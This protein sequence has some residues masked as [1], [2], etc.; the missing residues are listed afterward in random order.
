MIASIEPLASGFCL[1]DPQDA[2][3]IYITKL[4]RRFGEFLHSA[5]LSLQRQGE[6]N[7][8][9]AVQML[10]CT[11]MVFHGLTAYFSHFWRSVQ[12]APICS[13]MATA[14]TGLWYFTCVNVAQHLTQLLCKLRPIPLR[15]RCSSSIFRA[16]GLAARSLCPKGSVNSINIFSCFDFLILHVLDFIIPVDFYGTPLSELEVHLRTPCWTMLLNGQCGIIRQ[17]N[18]RS[19]FHVHEYFWL[20]SRTYSAAVSGF[21]YISLVENLNF[22]SR[23]SQSLLESLTSVGVY[24]CYECRGRIIYH[25]CRYTTVF[26][27]ELFQHCTQPYSLVLMTIAWKERCGHWIY[28]R[29]VSHASWQRCN[30]FNHLLRAICDIGWVIHMSFFEVARLFFR[31]DVSAR[32]HSAAPWVPP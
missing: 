19:W 25:T 18:D 7:T 20:I 29:L 13:S 4:R 30:S 14:R 28:H 1:T 27:F 9:D 23:A 16:E 22:C 21:Q 10:V 2:R 11:L 24:I 15:D 8:V 17:V 26:V 12:S 32:N 31:T 3:Y 5:S 6:E